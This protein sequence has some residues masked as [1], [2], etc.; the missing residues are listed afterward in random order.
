MFEQGKRNYVM[1]LVSQ[2]KH[3]SNIA[4]D[5]VLSFGGRSTAVKIGF[6]FS[7]ETVTLETSTRDIT[8]IK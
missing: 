4:F 8:W 3:V 6:I 7:K 2:M 5:Y 1:K